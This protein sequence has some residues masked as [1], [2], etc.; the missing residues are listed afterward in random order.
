HG[1][2][3]IGLCAAKAY[4]IYGDEEYLEVA[5]YAAEAVWGAGLLYKGVGLCHGVGGNGYIFLTLFK[6]TGNQI[7][8]DRAVSFAVACAEWEQKTKEGAFRGK[9]CVKKICLQIAPVRRKVDALRRRLFAGGSCT[10]IHT[11]SPVAR[12]VPDHPWSLYEGLAGGA[13]FVG[14]VVY[15]EPAAYKGF[16][17]LSDV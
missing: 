12:T 7:Y 17:G 11:A 9:I 15:F 4:E 2:P 1:A 10:L 14:D 16:P 13:Y 5:K 6:F 8:W 3:G